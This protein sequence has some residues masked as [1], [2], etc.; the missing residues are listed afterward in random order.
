MFLEEISDILK[1]NFV[2]LGLNKKKAKKLQ[3]GLNR[4]IK[5]VSFTIYF[6]CFSFPISIKL[7]LLLLFFLS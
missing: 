1:K 3:A 6:Y 2:H 7:G 5:A 4:F